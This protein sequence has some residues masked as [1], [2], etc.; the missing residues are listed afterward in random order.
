MRYYNQL[1]FV[2]ACIIFLSSKLVPAEGEAT[3]SPWS[4]GG[5]VGLLGSGPLPTFGLF[6]ER[7]I[8]RSD[9]KQVYSPVSGKP[10]K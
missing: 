3:Y 2:F 8:F 10:V 6:A 1:V 4:Y 5:T 7:Q 9:L